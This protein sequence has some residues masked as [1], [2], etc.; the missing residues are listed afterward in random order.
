M[1]CHFSLA[2]LAA[3]TILSSILSG[4][5]DLSTLDFKSKVSEL[6]LSSSGKISF[7]AAQFKETCLSANGDILSL[8]GT[9]PGHGWSEAD[10]I[11]LVSGELKRL[12]KVVLRIPGGGGYFSQTQTI[13]F[14]E[15][16]G[17]IY[18]LNLEERFA[19]NAKSS[20]FC[21]LYSEASDYLETCSNVGKLIK[22][23]PDRNEKYP[24]ASAQFIGWKTSIA[25][26]RARVTCDRTP[27][28]G[29]LPYRG[30]VISLSVENTKK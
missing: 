10:D 6:E 20:T 9:L 24:N 16:N 26:R 12:R 15:D 2:A 19:S 27:I 11:Q 8:R 28:S 5:L 25:G 3:I 23:R 7:V 14:K 17:R 22:R 30:V 21:A 1:K 13:H 4:C 29:T 18:F